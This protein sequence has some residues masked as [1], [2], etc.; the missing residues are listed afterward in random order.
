MVSRDSESDRESAEKTT[1]LLAKVNSR[2]LERVKHLLE[3]TPLLKM[4]LDWVD[5]FALLLNNRREILAVSEILPEKWQ[6]LDPRRLLGLRPGRALECVHEPRGEA[7]CGTGPGCPFCGLFATIQR[8]RGAEGPVDGECK[9]TIQGDEGEV[10][11][12]YRLQATALAIGEEVFTLVLFRPPRRRGAG[13]IQQALMPVD[14]DWPADIEG[15]AFVRKLGTGGMGSVFLVRDPGGRPFA[16]KTVRTGV[17][18]DSTFNERFD[19]E[20]EIALRLEHENVLRTFRADLTPQGILYMVC[21]YCP[22]GSAEQHLQWRGPLPLD[23]GLYWMIGSTRG[24]DYLWTEHK[25]IHRDIK[26]DN[27]LVDAE[28]RIKISDFGLARRCGVHSRLTGAGMILGSPHYISPEQ[29][30]EDVE[31]DIRSDLYSLGATFYELFTGAPPFDGPDEVSVMLNH[32]VKRWEPVAT[33]RSDLPTP[34]AQCID[35]LLAKNREDRPEDPSVLLSQL[36]EIAEKEG[37]DPDAC[38]PSRSSPETV[39]LKR[40]DAI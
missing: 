28:G 5:G 22:E 14:R 29:L 7:G 23:L 34:M 10:T 17:G 9:F 39:T 31:I 40:P 38:P 15:Y 36:L 21:E 32:A 11:Y 26:P 6:G 20:R 35:G 2:E 37:V 12:K 30:K 8:S 25:I 33:Q 16:L 13:G 19:R 3:E 18:G 4:L 27:L 24:L 1:N